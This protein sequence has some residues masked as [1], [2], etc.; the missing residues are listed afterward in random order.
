MKNPQT[1]STR[2]EVIDILRAIAL[3]GVLL[4]HIS[5][6]FAGWGSV[7]TN[8]NA[9]HSDQLSVADKG[10]NYLITL[11]LVNKSRALLSFL[12]GVSFYYQLNSFKG[13]EAKLKGWFARRMGALML[14]GL[15]HAY[16]LWSGDILRM[17]AVCGFSLLLVYK[18]D[19][20]NIL[21]VGLLFSFLLP[22]CIGIMQQ[23]FPY[24]SI[25]DAE[26]IAMFEDYSS[27][28]YI[29]LFT[30][31]RLR[32]A[33]INFNPYGITSYMSEILGNFMLGL[34]AI[35]SNLFNKL[36]ANKTLL[37]KYLGFSLLIGVV[38]SVTF[39]HVL[40]EKVL[41][42]P[43]FTLPVAYLDALDILYK[44]SQQAIALFNMCAIIYLYSNTTFRYR[45]QLLIPLGR[46]SLTNYIMHSVMAVFLFNGVGLGLIGKY[47]PS[48]A[49]SIGIIYF[50]VQ[51]FYSTWWLKRFTMG[52]LEYVWRSLISGK[53]QTINRARLS[54]LAVQKVPV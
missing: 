53:W 15:L 7:Y 13:E 3:M 44:V 21:K 48:V 26:K 27:T 14:I 49:F 19:I 25:T 54:Q 8:P 38:C 47:R 42:I 2:V 33:A 36:A 9:L 30:A 11:F 4:V 37:Y 29:D 20:K 32:D 22:T 16:L 24:S 46:M 1:P 23:H 40:V 41:H 5:Y 45:L 34:W 39:I 31:N 52:P 50:A 6:E 10:L 43:E 12:F 28:R 18:W 51:A 35:R 17:Y